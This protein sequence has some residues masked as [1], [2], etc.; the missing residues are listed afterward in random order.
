MQARPA[1]AAAQAQPATAAGNNY[2]PEQLA[3]LRRKLNGNMA[4]PAAAGGPPAA[5]NGAAAPAAAQGNYTPEQL[6]FLRRKASSLGGA[7]LG[8]PQSSSWVN[9]SS[10]VPGCVTPGVPRG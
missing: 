7:K 5:G 10:Y 1:A 9:S 6:A 4:A 2:T 3:F 8:I